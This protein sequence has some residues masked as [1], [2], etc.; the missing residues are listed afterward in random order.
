MKLVTN[1]KDLIVV[2]LT[3]GVVS[4]LGVVIIGDYYVAVK[5][6]RGINT[7]VMTL[8]KMSLTGL[9]GVIAGYVGGK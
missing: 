8:M 5:E 9:I 1:L 7:E 4:L 3:L 2:I 6:G